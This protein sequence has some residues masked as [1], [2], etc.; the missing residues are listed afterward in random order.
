MRFDITT[1]LATLALTAFADRMEVFTTCN[2]FCDSGHGIFYTDYGTYNFN[3]NEG[4]RTI[5]VPALTD[6]CIDW[7]KRR[8]HFRFSGQ[9]KRCMIQ[10]SEN[11]L[12][13]SASSCWKTTW[14]EVPCNWRT[15]SEGDPAT[16]IASSA[17][18]T[19][20]KE[21]AGN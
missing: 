8:A 12:A 19:A 1:I 9:G 6:F 11:R 3:A 4:C 14:K 15:N 21:V 17:F 13:C 18:I 16:E 20:T 2:P 5:P 10:D 7:G